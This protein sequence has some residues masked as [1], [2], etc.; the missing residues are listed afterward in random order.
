ML[1]DPGQVKQMGRAGGPQA[2]VQIG[3]VQQIGLDEGIS[4]H[5]GRAHAPEHHRLEVVPRQ[6]AQ[7]VAAD[8]AVGARDQDLHDPTASKTSRPG[9]AVTKRPPHSPM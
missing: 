3:A 7:H 8:E 6:A 2:F 1:G 4:S 9:T 5:P